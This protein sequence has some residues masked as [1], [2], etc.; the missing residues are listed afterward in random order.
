MR[1]FGDAGKANGGEPMRQADNERGR[2]YINLA[3]KATRTV[4]SIRGGVS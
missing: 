1:L 4:T 2:N 3:G